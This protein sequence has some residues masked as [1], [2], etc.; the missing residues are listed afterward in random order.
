M[1]ISLKLEG[2]AELSRKLKRMANDS[3]VIAA[4]VLT[5]SA[6]RAATQTRR[7]VSRDTG[8]QTKFLKR[9]ITHYKATRNRLAASLWIGMKNGIPLAR[10][11]GAHTTLDGVLTARLSRGRKI[12]QQTF[13]ARMPSGHV[14]QFVRAPNSKH[15]RRPDGQN[16]E[17]P[18]E[19]PKFRLD[20]AR[21]GRIA[22]SKASDQM[23]DFFPVELKR[24]IEL[25]ARSKR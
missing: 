7:K 14:G 13:R 12:R 9:R 8:L 22:V 2:S 3:P 1:T 18:I 21:V 20:R 10:L 16:T 24:R 5:A 15:R 25:R 4:S 17:L 23:R 19:E 11:S 6:K